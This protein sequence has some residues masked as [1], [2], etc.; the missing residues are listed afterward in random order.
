M[1]VE[2]ASIDRSDLLVGVRFRQGELRGHMQALCSSLHAEVMLQ[3]L[4]QEVIKSREKEGEILKQD[5]IRSSIARRLGNDIAGAALTDNSV[6]G[7]IEMMVEAIQNFHAILTDERLFNWHAVLFP[8][9]RNGMRRIEVSGWRT[10][11]SGPMQ[12]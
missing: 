1:Q 6:E 5:Q 4:T 2:S 10:G 9:G 12:V 7:V 11:E 3:I 8:I